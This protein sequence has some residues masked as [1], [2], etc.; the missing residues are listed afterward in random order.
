MRNMFIALMFMATSAFAIEIPSNCR[1]PN[2]SPGYCAWVS[3]ETLGRVHGI[4]Q[5]KH[6]FQNRKKSKDYTFINHYGQWET[7]ER[8]VGYGYAIRKELDDL[9]VRYWMQDSGQFKTDLLKHAKTHGCVVTLKPSDICD[10]AHCIIITNIN[11]KNVWFYNCNC[12]N[13][14]WIASRAWFNYYWT[15]MVVVLER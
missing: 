3:L 7:H 6:L 8:N 5:L 4:K 11:D 2:E 13:D 1:I 14:K 10:E 9:K 12:P 15:G